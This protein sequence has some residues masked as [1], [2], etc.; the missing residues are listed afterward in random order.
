[1]AHND[2]EATKTCEDV[3]MAAADQGEAGEGFSSSSLIRPPSEPGT[4]VGFEDDIFGG[5]DGDRMDEDPKVP[6]LPRI[7]QVELLPARTFAS[8]EALAAAF[9]TDVETLKGLIQSEEF[10][11]IFQELKA[12]CLDKERAAMS[13]LGAKRERME[14]LATVE[15][16]LAQGESRGMQRYSLPEKSDQ[17]TWNRVD[18]HARY[19]FRMR[20]RFFLRMGGILHGK[21]FTDATANQRIWFLAKRADAKNAPSKKG[22]SAGTPSKKK[23]PV[24]LYEETVFGKPRP[25][26]DIAGKGKAEKASPVGP[27]SGPSAG[28]SS[29]PSAGKSAKALFKSGNLVGAE[30]MEA[31]ADRL[32]DEHHDYAIPVLDDTFTPVAEDEERS[33]EMLKLERE[34]PDVDEHDLTD[35]YNAYRAIT[36]LTTAGLDAR[37]IASMLKRNDNSPST[38]PNEEL[39]GK[40]GELMEEEA[41]LIAMLDEHA[42]EGAITNFLTES[43]D[44]KALRMSV[45]SLMDNPNFQRFDYPKA[46][47]ALNLKGGPYPRLDGMSLSLWLTW[48]QVVGAHA[49]YDIAMSRYARGFLLA[50]IVG[51]GKTV[52]LLSVILHVSSILSMPC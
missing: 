20:Q 2:P 19:L 16:A 24:G 25:K 18:W 5:D 28:K 31:G 46:Y 12:N 29:G 47:T 10:Q 42:A 14:N 44:A 38:P 37:A 34:N 26:R 8:M 41:R 51:L 11:E 1:M 50:D 22:V 52:T 27:S 13:G 15:I 39:R 3:T 36:R 43:S 9:K 33:A 7:E 21:G 40:M 45:G 35:P 48:W 17:E 23:K 6:D 32:E 30:Y 49:L 4:P